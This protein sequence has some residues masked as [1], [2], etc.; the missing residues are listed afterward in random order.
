MDLLWKWQALT[1]AL[2]TQN[3][4]V[5]SALCPLRAV[6]PCANISWHTN[7]KKV[8]CNSQF[9]IYLL[10]SLNAPLLSHRFFFLLSSCFFDL[11]EQ[12]WQSCPART[13]REN[14]VPRTQPKLFQ[15]MKITLDVTL[16]FICFFE[17]EANK[18]TCLTQWKK[19]IS[20]GMIPCC[21]Y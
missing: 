3:A 15:Q 20:A 4:S 10:L 11:P 7:Q 17:R 12:L 9:A 19:G 8:N 1:I 5:L 13:Q 21:A 14:V 18:V 6:R 2:C 16:G